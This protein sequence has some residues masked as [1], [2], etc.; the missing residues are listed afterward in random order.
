MQK[1]HLFIA[2]KTY[3]E[4]HYI[5][6][7][8]ELVKQLYEAYVKNTGDTTNKPFTVGG[9]TYAGILDKGVAYGM[10]FPGEVELAHQKDEYLAIESLLKGILIYI[11]AI[12]SLGEIDA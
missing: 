11:D 3:K 9:G 8:D 2:N 7:N 6:P 4:P 1:Y 10:G 12:L 5:S